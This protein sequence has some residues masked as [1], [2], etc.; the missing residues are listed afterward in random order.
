MSPPKDQ[1]AW[2]HKTNTPLQVGNAALP[3]AGAD[4]IVVKNA[5]FAINPLD[6][7][8]QKTGI[9]FQQWPTIFGCDVAGEAYEVGP[10][11]HRCK[12]GDRVIA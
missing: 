7:H 4:E 10:S 2:L 3:T 9:F 11:V 5:A 1:A 8:M 6:C 12:K